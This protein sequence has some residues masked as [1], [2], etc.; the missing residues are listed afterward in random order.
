[1]SVTN[2][3]VAAYRLPGK[4]MERQLASGA[5]EE[6]A[7]IFLMAS[8]VVFFI[9]QLPVVSRNAH[10]NQTEM[11]PELGANVLAWL[12]IAPLAMY[13]VAAALRVVMR[14]FGCKASWFSVR[15]AL[16]WTMLA[17]APLILLNGLTEGMIGPGAEQTLVGALWLA[18]FLWILFGSLRAVCKASA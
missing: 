18:S 15:L 3:M 13:V 5:G 14:I 4:S 16:F 17:G 10:L 8:C 1:M 9:A 12:F 2:D 6:R 7:L 11:G